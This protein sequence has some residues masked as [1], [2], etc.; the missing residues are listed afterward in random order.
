MTNFQIAFELFP[1]CEVEVLLYLVLNHFKLKE[2]AHK[3]TLQKYVLSLL[4]V[5][6]ENHFGLKV[7]FIV[8][9]L[10]ISKKN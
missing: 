8:T 4:P 6:L 1:F 7:Q 10:K 3:G 2:K 5:M 9:A